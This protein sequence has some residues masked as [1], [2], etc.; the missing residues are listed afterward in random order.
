[1]QLVWGRLQHGRET[2]DKAIQNMAYQKN[3]EKKRK[4]PP[5]PSTGGSKKQSAMVSCTTPLS[6][7]RRRSVAGFSTPSTQRTKSP[8]DQPTPMATPDGRRSVSKF[9]LP[10]DS[11]GARRPPRVPSSAKTRMVR[12]WLLPLFH[13]GRAFPTSHWIR[14]SLAYSCSCTVD[15]VTPSDVP[16]WVNNMME[17]LSKSASIGRIIT[18]VRTIISLSRYFHLDASIHLFS[19]RIDRRVIFHFFDQ[20]RQCASS[21]TRWGF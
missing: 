12:L 16:A 10:D 9:S 4:A 19:D 15:A 1:M 8:G 5:T 20:L 6:S 18:H 21:G 11:L 14:P 7:N 17:A 13:R 3:K 2:Y